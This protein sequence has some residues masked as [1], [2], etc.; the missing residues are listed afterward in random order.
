MFNYFTFNP[1]TCVCLSKDRSFISKVMLFFVFSGFSWWDEIVH[2]V[3]IG[4]INDRRCLSFLFVTINR[5]YT[6]IAHSSFPLLF[7]VT[8]IFH[9]C[10]TLL[11]CFDVCVCVFVWFSLFCLSV[12]F[13]FFF[14]VFC[15]CIFPFLARVRVGRLFRSQLGLLLFFAF[16]LC[17]VPMLPASLD[18]PFVIFRFSSL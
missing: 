5:W 13:S 3:D 4:G 1:A 17:L 9:W 2:F 15:F 12:V 16:I 18:C 14:L 10:E 6:W 11:F 8:F 7:S